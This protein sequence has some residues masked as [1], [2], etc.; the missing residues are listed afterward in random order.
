[1]GI[2]EAILATVLLVGIGIFIGM[3]LGVWILLPPPEVGKGEKE[4]A[5]DK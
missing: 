2:P 3:G 5:D 4:T 1:M